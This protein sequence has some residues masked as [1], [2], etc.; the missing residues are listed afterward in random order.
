MGDKT[1]MPLNEGE[2][3]LL[4]KF[5]DGQCAFLERGKAQRLI[6]QSQSACEYMDMLRKA[7][8]AAQTLGRQQTLKVDLW[9][10]VSR[11]IDAEEHAAIFLGKRD[12]HAHPSLSERVRGFFSNAWNLGISGAA[13]TA[14]LAFFMLLPATTPTSDDA[15]QMV[16]M[17]RGVSYEAADASRAANV[18]GA[19]ASSNAEVRPVG[20]HGR[21]QILDEQTANVV[22]VD[23][24]RS[25]GRLRM[26]H[27][28]SERSAIIWVKRRNPAAQIRHGRRPGPVMLEQSTPVAYSVSS[29]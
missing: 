6:E 20:I 23:W 29:K 3:V 7:A 11:R 26:L 18:G 4:M 21:P 8:Q 10:E 14:G 9:Q 17:V 22:E 15:E 24:M 16:D 19:L 2:E 1:N 5:F 27:E 25:D 12:T 13:V 28:P